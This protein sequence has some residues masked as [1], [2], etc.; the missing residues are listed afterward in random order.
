MPT[1]DCFHPDLE[2]EALFATTAQWAECSHICKEL[3]AMRPPP[4]GPRRDD[5][6]EM[7]EDTEHL[8]RSWEVSLTP[9]NLYVSLLVQYCEGRLE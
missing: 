5:K 8:L 2:R 6:W 3:H 9:Y 4:E 7:D 1:L